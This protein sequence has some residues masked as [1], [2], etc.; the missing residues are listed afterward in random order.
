[1]RRGAPRHMQF[2]AEIAPRGKEGAYISLAVLPYFLGKIG[3]TVMADILTE[4]YFAADMTSF[5]DH[6]VSW[7]WIAVMCLI[8]PVGMIIFKDTFTASEK[9][10]EDEA[11]AT[12]AA[13]LSEGESAS[14]ES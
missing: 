14:T 4:R 10:A 12:R 5:P 9:M 2:S 3:A 1:M 8:S 13:E 7:F 11:S 6:E